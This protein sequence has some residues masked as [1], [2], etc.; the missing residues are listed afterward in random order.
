MQRSVAAET[1]RMRHEDNCEYCMISQCSISYLYE[2]LETDNSRTTNGILKLWSFVARLTNG[3]QAW[4]LCPRNRGLAFEDIHILHVDVSSSL[5]FYHLSGW[6][7]IDSSRHWKAL[8]LYDRTESSR[9]MK[10]MCSETLAYLGLLYMEL[11]SE[12]LSFEI[13]I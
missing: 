11:L 8:S 6:N 2:V 5:L 3:R 4:G 9:K 13:A 7:T 1:I 10:L 12:L